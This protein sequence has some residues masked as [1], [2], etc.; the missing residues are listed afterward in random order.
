MLPHVNV[1]LGYPQHQP[2]NQSNSIEQS[3]AY[4]I[5]TVNATRPRST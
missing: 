5:Q 1:L 3:L 2:T 4:L